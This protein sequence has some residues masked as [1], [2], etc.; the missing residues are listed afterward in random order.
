MNPLSYL[1]AVALGVIQGFTEFLPISSSGHLAITQQLMGLTAES[2][3]LLIFNVASHVGTLIAVGLVFAGPIRLYF[4]RLLTESGTGFGGRRIAW[5]IAG[6]AALATLP[7]GVVGLLFQSVIEPA[8]G[9]P[10][11]IGVALLITGTW[12]YLSGRFPR[13][14]QG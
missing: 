10:T 6:L 9:N 2:Q 14:R 5:R 8:F 11:G 4:R 13:P 7:A 1:Q 12:L 3:P